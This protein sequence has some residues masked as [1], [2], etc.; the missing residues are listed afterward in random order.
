MVT[1]SSIQFATAAI[2]T[3]TAPYSCY[4]SPQVATPSNF[5]HNNANLPKKNF[6]DIFASYSTLSPHIQ[7]IT[8][9][10]QSIQPSSSYLHY[11]SPGHSLSKCLLGYLLRAGRGEKC[12]HM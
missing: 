8:K 3:T 6:Q 9:S 4:L 10:Y 7:R 1:E 5:C 2:I 12:K 11:L